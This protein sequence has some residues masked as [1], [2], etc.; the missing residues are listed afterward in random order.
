MIRNLWRSALY[1]KLGL[2]VPLSAIDQ[3]LQLGDEYLVQGDR[4]QFRKDLYPCVFVCK[5]KDWE[6][7]NS[8]GLMM[9]VGEEES[10]NS[11]ELSRH[12]D[13]CGWFHR[14]CLV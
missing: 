2:P 1:M 5:I 13:D 12:G 4:L 3:R 14:R 7:R 9:E 8:V 6:L 10:K 11:K